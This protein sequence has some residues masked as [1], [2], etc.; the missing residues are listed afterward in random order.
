MKKNQK[1]LKRFFEKCHKF[2]FSSTYI[3]RLKKSKDLKE[4][5]NVGA[6]KRVSRVITVFFEK[7]FPTNFSLSNPKMYGN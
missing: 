3:E 5:S 6:E 1:I 7:T 2:L 4:Y